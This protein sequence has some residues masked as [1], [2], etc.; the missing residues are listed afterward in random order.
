MNSQQQEEFII[1]LRDEFS[2]KLNKIDKNTKRYSSSVNDLTGGLKRMAF[3]LAAAFS[4]RKVVESIAEHEQAL[5]ELSSITGLTGKD[6]AELNTRAEQLS[7]QFGTSGK[8][9]LKSM[10]LIGSKK[11]DLLGNADAMAQVTEQVD[12]LAKAGSIEGVQAADALTKAMNMYGV[13]ADQAAMFTDIL[14]TSQQKGTA[15]I[16]SLSESF[17]NVGSAAKA[18]GLD[19]EQTNVLLQAL[20]KGGME[21][22]EAGTKLR[23]ILLRLAKTGR[24]ELNP[25]YT[26]MREILKTLKKEVTDVT[27]AQNMFGMENAAA[28]LTLID[29][30]EV[31]D[32]LTGSLNNV[33]NALKQAKTNTNTLKGSWDKVAGS[34]DG[35]IN[36][37]VNGKGILSTFLKDSLDGVTKLINKLTDFNKTS[38]EIGKEKGTEFAGKIIKLTDKLSLKE[39]LE[40]LKK[41]E[42]ISKNGVTITKAINKQQGE[43]IQNIIKLGKGNEAIRSSQNLLLAA[44]YSNTKENTE[45]NLFFKQVGESIKKKK[46]SL[47]S[48]IAK[49]GVYVPTSKDE[50]KKEDKGSLTDVTKVTAAAPKVFNITIGNLVENFEVI[51]QNLNEASADIKKQ[52]IEVF[53]EAI[54]DVQIIS[55]S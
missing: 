35:F 41:Y 13:G 22:A 19:F 37:V 14:A 20:A 53:V 2:S 11:P 16:I 34:F 6:L 30:R 51:S 25:A 5:A 50:I 12:I 29:Q 21:G 3:G 54:N 4:A 31:V 48:N 38:G 18:S 45:R 27:K 52:I 8:D 44:Q 46:A 33:G 26:D 39:Q 7:R 24:R 9:I 47:F 32:K 28:A 40:S 23:G 17:K 55:N 49:S 1:R 10:T 43:R 42:E 15:T 36:S